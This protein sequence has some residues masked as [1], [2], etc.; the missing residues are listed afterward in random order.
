MSVA[1]TLCD[2]TEYERR[3]NKHDDS[4]FGRSEAESLPRFIQF[5]APAFCNH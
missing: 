3:E 2:K 4:F 5:K 1:I